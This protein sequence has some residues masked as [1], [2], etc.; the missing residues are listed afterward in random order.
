MVT[1]IRSCLT[2]G[3]RKTHAMSGRCCRSKLSVWAA[4]CVLVLCWFYVFP[5]YRLP[6]YEEIVDEVSR[7]GHVWRKNDTGIHVYR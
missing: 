2:W 4:L 5:V 1:L 3:R 7:Q 6:S